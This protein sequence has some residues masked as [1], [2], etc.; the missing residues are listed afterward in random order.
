MAVK[1]INNTTGLNSLILI[2]FVFDIF[3]RISINNILLIITIKKDKAIK[4]IIK[5]I[6]KLYTKRYI[7]KALQIYNRP[8]IINVL[9]LIL[10]KKV[11]V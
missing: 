11:L 9:R 6:T 10:K 4:K 2:F 8:N 3:P 5:K 1:A 7:N